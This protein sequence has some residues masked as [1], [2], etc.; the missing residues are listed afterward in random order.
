MR[1]PSGSAVNGSTRR[2]LG[3]CG[4]LSISAAIR[5]TVCPC[6]QLVAKQRLD[7]RWQAIRLTAQCLQKEPRLAELVLIRRLR[8]NI[9]HRLLIGRIFLRRRARKLEVIQNLRVI[10]TQAVRKHAK[11]V[12]SWVAQRDVSQLMSARIAARE[13]VTPR[14]AEYPACRG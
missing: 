4:A 10:E 11:S 2:S 13:S 1:D 9:C 12:G 6:H 8:S 14:P 7:Q 5:S 3:N